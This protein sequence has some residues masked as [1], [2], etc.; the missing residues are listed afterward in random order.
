MK[1]VQIKEYGDNSVIEIVETDKPKITDG[2]VLVEVHAASL[3]GVDTSIRSGETK[4][5]APLKFPVT[6]GGDFAGKIV[7]VAKDV[8]NVAIGDKVYG[9]SLAI[10]G[11]SGSL[12]E[13]ANANAGQI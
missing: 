9:L 3:N 4:E 8:G 11:N 5:M 13:Y 7:E 6:L 2:Q 10:F 1:A 12:A